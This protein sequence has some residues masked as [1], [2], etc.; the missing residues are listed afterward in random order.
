M[1]DEKRKKLRA[2]LK[3]RIGEKSIQRSTK[4]T[5]E[6][7]LDKTMA[8]SGIDMK[9]LKEDMERLQKECG[10]KFELNMKNK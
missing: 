8:D 1:D 2:S 5:K 10:G 6:K 4:Q 3:A 9:K 7:V